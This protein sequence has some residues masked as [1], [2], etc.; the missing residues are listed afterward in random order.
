[1]RGR[2]GRTYS[3]RPSN[4]IL[5]KSQNLQKQTIKTWKQALELAL[6]S[7]DPSRLELMEVYTSILLDN[8]LAS[9]IETRVLKVL[10]SKFRFVD[11]NGNEN[12]DAKKLF[13]K[14]WFE[15]FLTHVMW[16]KFKGTTVIELWD[17]DE[18]MELI[19]TGLI[20]REN[21]NFSK[22]Y[23]TKE[24]GDD[25]GTQYKEGSYKPYYIQIGDNRD[26]GLLKDV[27]PA[28]IA[29]KFALAAWLE[30]TQKYGIPPRYVVTDSYSTTRHQE[31]ANMMH[32]MVNNHY[33]VL[34]GN[35]KIEVL[36]GIQGDPHEV[37]D[38]IIKRYNSE[39]TKRVLG[40]DS[41]AGTQDAKGTYGSMKIMQDVANDR[42][43]SDKTFCKHLVNDELIPRLIEISP[44][45]KVLANLTFD[46]DNFQELS[47]NELISAV[48]DLSAAG[49][50]A[51]VEYITQKTGIP[52]V[53]MKQET[54][55][56]PSDEEDNSKKKVNS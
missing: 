47:A 10:R 4:I 29:K 3:N 49:F 46:W 16:S 41:G 20:P 48:K 5:P 22:G 18:N 55:T 9:I 39:K 34:Q 36:N 19:R 40:H 12:G 32:Q 15:Q 7:E 33:A 44:A 1:M 51:D 25:K 21:C 42:H 11:D 28:A 24:V 52:I 6:A 54:S 45:Y 2:I 13:E 30:L 23:F 56:T 26:L 17:T 31:L 38:Q 8:H 35:E 43:E 27:A 53:G 37:F 14:Q 50:I